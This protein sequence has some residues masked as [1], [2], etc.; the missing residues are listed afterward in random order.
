MQRER[1]RGGKKKSGFEM[2]SKRIIIDIEFE[3]PYNFSAKENELCNSLV[4]K[5]PRHLE[6]DNDCDFEGNVACAC[7]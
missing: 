6:T 3:N 1:K 5:R 2:Q 7:S 4:E